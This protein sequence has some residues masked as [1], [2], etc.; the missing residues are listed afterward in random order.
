MKTTKLTIDTENEMFCEI[1]DDYKEMSVAQI[2][3]SLDKNGATDLL[4]GYDKTRAQMERKIENALTDSELLDD[5][6]PT[7]DDILD[8]WMDLI[9]PTNTQIATA[10]YA[11]NS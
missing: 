3:E 9:C 8:E 10:I 5:T 7:V 11:M 1:L 2:T 4:Y 6:F